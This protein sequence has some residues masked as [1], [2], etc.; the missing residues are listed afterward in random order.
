[1]KQLSTQA[2]QGQYILFF[3]CA[4]FLLPSV[5]A[6]RTMSFERNKKEG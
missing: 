4:F 3:G 5:P 1:M 6:E 2:I